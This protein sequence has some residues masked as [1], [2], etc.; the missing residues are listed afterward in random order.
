MGALEKTH[1][2]W[3]AHQQFLRKR[4]ESKQRMKIA[5]ALI[6]TCLVATILA[7]PG[8]RCDN[9]ERCT[10]DDCKE[11]YGDCTCTWSHLDAQA[12]NPASI[13]V[14]PTCIKPKNGCFKDAGSMLEA[15]G[16]I[17]YIKNIIQPLLCT[18]DYNPFG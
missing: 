11:E 2:K 4:T 3:R 5:T 13:P 14:P 15:E 8:K 18:S 12:S 1:R 16:V 9:K 17:P 6:V 7:C 10:C